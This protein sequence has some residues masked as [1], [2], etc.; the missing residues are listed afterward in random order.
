MAVLAISLAAAANLSLPGCDS[1]KEDTGGK[2]KQRLVRQLLPGPPGV[3][4]SVME[5]LASADK[6]LMLGELYAGVQ[7]TARHFPATTIKRYLLDT[8]P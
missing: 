6:A 4:P 2:G 3:R 5:L 8:I 7:M 1:G